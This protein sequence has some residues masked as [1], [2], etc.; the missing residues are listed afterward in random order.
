MTGTIIN[1][2][3][4]ELWIKEHS[5]LDFN[6]TEYNRYPHWEN[7]EMVQPSGT[8]Y[9]ETRF[10]TKRI[11]DDLNSTFGTN[12]EICVPYIWTRDDLNKYYWGYISPTKKYAG[13]YGC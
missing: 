4:A 8:P 7:G 10:F 12:F 11:V 5:K 2:P 6:I 9:I 3:E 1:S 13:V